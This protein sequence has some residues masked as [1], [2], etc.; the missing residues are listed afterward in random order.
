M[1]GSLKTL[2]V[3]FARGGSKRLPRKN[4]RPLAGHPLVEWS[5]RAALASGIERVILSTDD[6]EISDIGRNV[7]ID[8][9]FRRPAAL[10]DDFAD[11]VDVILHA[12]ETSETHYE[13]QYDVV[14]LIQPT[15]PFV[16]SWDLDAC[17]ERLSSEDLNCVFTA[18]EADEHPRWMW[19]MNADGVAAPFMEG[20]LSADEQHHQNLTPVLYPSGAAWAIRIAAMRKQGT[21]YCGPH[22]IVEMPWKR[23][24][25]IDTE[26]DWSLAETIAAEYGFR[27]VADR[28]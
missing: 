7:G 13:E 25:D 9:P 24:I 14:V 2:G 21:I 3:V 23:S 5:C 28:E 27:P 6:D 8:V 22:G 17:V 15:T 4:V 16:Q 11:W 1:S 12:V 26:L 19:K 18:R 20:V 10:A